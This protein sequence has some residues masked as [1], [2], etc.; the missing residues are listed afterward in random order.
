MTAS[1]SV[2]WT[3]FSLPSNLV[4]GHVSSSWS[5][6]GHNHTQEGVQICIWHGP[7]L[8]CPETVEQRPCVERDIEIFAS[9]RL[10]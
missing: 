3:S 7:E 6:A 8:A 4:S 10:Q 1:S 9:C 2:S 5:V